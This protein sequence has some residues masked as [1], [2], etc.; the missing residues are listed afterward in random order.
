MAAKLDA[1]TPAGTTI[2][3]YT[4]DNDYKPA[5][6]DAL[7]W[8]TSIV[9]PMIGTKKFSEEAFAESTLCRIWQTNKFSRVNFDPSV[10]PFG[11]DV[12]TVLSV[13]PKPKV[14]LEDLPPSNPPLPYY[15][16]V[17]NYIGQEMDNKPIV[18][19]SYS[20][21]NPLKAFEST[22]RPELAFVVS[23]KGAGRLTAEESAEAANNPFVKGYDNPFIICEEMREYGWMVS[24]DYTASV[25]GYILT[26][27]KE[28]QIYPRLYGDLVAV[29][30]I[31][32]PVTPTNITDSIALPISMK[33]VLVAKALHYISWKQ[34][35]KITLNTATTNELITILTPKK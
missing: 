31:P 32:V 14:Y 24:V 28:I 29:F 16:E 34:G 33:G 6:T 15:N 35:D 20:T 5:I 12:W 7:E 26:V 4:W 9:T 22:I 18:S 11:S 8:I 25:G 19:K 17:F 30:Y 10:M 13:R 27:P 2:D 23:D 1:E 3:Y 21:G